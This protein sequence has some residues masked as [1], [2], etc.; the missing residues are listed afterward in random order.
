VVFQPGIGTVRPGIEAAHLRRLQRHEMGLE[1]REASVHVVGDV[2]ADE[3]QT[4]GTP[5]A[6]AGR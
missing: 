3:P 6:T 1:I 4:A 2:A 5:S